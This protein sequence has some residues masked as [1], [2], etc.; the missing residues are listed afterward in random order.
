[1][2]KYYSHLTT[3]NHQ[4]S[5]TEW[6]ESIGESKNARIIK[7]E[8]NSKHQRLEMLK[9]EIN[10]PYISPK[11]VE[12]LD[13]LNPTPE[14]A[15][16]LK[17]KGK[18]FCAI[19]LVPKNTNLPKLRKRGLTLQKCYTS[20]FLKQKINFKDYYAEICPHSDVTLWSIVFI[21]NK[22]GIF[23]EIVQ[24][25][26]F[27]IIHGDAKSIIY[28]FSYDFNSWQWSKYNPEIAGYVKRAVKNLLVK[29]PATEKNLK[30]K[31]NAKIFNNYLGGY[32]EV[33]VWPD[34]KGYFFDYNRLLPNYI[35]ASKIGIV[36]PSNVNILEGLAAFPGLVAGK[37]KKVAVKDLTSVKFNK[38]LIL[39]TSNTA[40]RFLIIMKKAKAIITD[41]GSIL[42]HASIIARELKIPCIVGTKNATKLL[43]DGDSVEVDANKGIVKV[44]NN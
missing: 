2:K 15:K 4:P 27:Q 8:D 9:K 5:L 21:V 34:K 36:N 20:W 22:Q 11:R 31:L 23:G 17:N 25:H 29:N 1:M 39:V 13:L 28:H 32:F 30:D 7:N 38:G 16:I 37:I 43:K 3:S 19:R 40:V 18:E 33:A 35:S 26:G 41:R 14:I 10:L 24:G 44:L 42:S 12:A 6:F